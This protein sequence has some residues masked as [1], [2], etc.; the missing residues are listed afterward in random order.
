MLPAD[1][2]TEGESGVRLYAV[3]AETNIV[4]AALDVEVDGQPA[5]LVPHGHGRMAERTCR[6]GR[7]A[8]LHLMR[9]ELFDRTFLV[10]Q[11]TC[12]SADSC[13][14]I[15]DEAV[16]IASVAWMRVQALE[17]EVMAGC[18]HNLAIL[19]RRHVSVGNC[20]G[21]RCQA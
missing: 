17:R 10:T 3:A 8:R 12:I 19:E 14:A 20:N 2:S 9:I 16:V 11:E 4:K 18:A 6:L 15:P 7:I 13:L 1:R 21:T 5:V